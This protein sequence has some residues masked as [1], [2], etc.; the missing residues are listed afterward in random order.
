M[1]DAACGNSIRRVNE[2]LRTNM[3]FEKALEFAVISSWDELIKPGGKSSI[4]VEYANVAGIPVPSLQV[5]DTH[6]GHENRVCDYSVLP[7]GDSQLQRIQFTNSYA[8]QTL[9]EALDLVML[10]QSH[11]TRPGDRCVKGLVQIGVPSE[12][13]RASAAQ[14]WHSMMTEL[15]RKAPP[16]YAQPELRVGIF[17]ESKTHAN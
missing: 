8:S 13:D 16:S 2:R 7:S 9:A 12:E 4:H 1:Q 17:T 15:V 14:W 3:D 11:F 5:W 10:N 6:K